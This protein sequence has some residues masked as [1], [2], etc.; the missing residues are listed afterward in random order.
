M[1]IINNFNEETAVISAENNVNDRR[2]E[3]ITTVIEKSTLVRREINSYA[4]TCC[5]RRFATF[6]GLNQH[7]R[8]C[9]TKNR[10]S[11]VQESAGYTQLCAGHE[12]G[13]EVGVHAMMDIFGDDTT[14][15]VLQV[16]AENAFNSLNREVMIHNVKILCP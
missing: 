3:E 5:E 2:S 11:D 1:S 16:Y 8:F 15:G 12:G 6:R 13:C 7:L 4:C 14:E 10:K 9:L